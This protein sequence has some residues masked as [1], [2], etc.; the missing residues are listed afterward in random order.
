MF[1]ESTKGLYI[2]AWLYAYTVVT[3]SQSLSIQMFLSS[4]SLSRHE[5]LFH[6]LR[7]QCLNLTGGFAAPYHLCGVHRRSFI[8][9]SQ[10]D[11][12]QTPFGT[13]TRFHGSLDANR[14]H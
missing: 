9:L 14:L 12:L 6:V 5:D 11:S 3:P 8:F 1:A 4:Y 2:L 13:N 7:G 10:I